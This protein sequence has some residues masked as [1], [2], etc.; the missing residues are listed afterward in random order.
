MKKSRS[1]IAVVVWVVGVGATTPQ[2][3]VDLIPL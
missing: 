3:A 1:T 2:R